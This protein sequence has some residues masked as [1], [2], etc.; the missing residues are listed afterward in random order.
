MAQFR[1]YGFIGVMTKPYSLKTLSETV[2][3]IITGSTT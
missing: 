3:K 2:Q 1:E